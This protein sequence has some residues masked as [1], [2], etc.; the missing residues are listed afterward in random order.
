[1]ENLFLFSMFSFLQARVTFYSLL[2]N[3]GFSL[4]IKNKQTNK[5]SIQKNLAHGISLCSDMWSRFFFPLSQSQRLSPLNQDKAWWPVIFSLLY[6]PFIFKTTPWME[7]ENS[8]KAGSGISFLILYH[9]CGKHFWI[10][11]CTTRKQSLHR[12]TREQNAIQSFIYF[13]C[14]FLVTL[15]LNF[16]PKRKKKKKRLF[17]QFASHIYKTH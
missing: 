17:T 15:Y 14:F 2:Q 1:M 4:V 9:Y 12:Q 13:F 7:E 10:S 5:L 11:D 3:T 6:F 16:I 8:V